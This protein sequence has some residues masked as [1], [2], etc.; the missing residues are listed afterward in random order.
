MFRSYGL[1]RSSKKWLALP[2]SLGASYYESGRRSDRVSTAGV[3]LE[4][5]LEK[6]LTYLAFFQ[7]SE[8]HQEFLQA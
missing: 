5:H 3:V 2:A 6:T 7:D 4:H 1:L 8:K